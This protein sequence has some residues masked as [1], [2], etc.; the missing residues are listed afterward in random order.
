M[1]QLSAMA[2]AFGIGPVTDAIVR[3]EAALRA[4]AASVAVRPPSMPVAAM[5]ATKTNCTERTSPRRTA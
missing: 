3:Y 5:T 4:V 2:M 1:P